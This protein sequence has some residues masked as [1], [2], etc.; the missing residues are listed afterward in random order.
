[1][2]KWKNCKEVGLNVNIAIAGGLIKCGVLVEN[3]PAMF[4]C[5]S[6]DV[7]ISLLDPDTL[8]C[9]VEINEFIDETKQIIGDYF[10][11]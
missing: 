4:A 5:M 6:K 9:A 11:S 10:D 1:M 2:D 3:P 7:G 8:W